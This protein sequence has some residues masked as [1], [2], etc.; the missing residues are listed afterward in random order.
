MGT[1]IWLQPDT[2]PSQPPLNNPQIGAFESSTTLLS[3][4]SVM[5]PPT[6]T[7]SSKNLRAHVDFTSPLTSPLTSPVRAPQHP[8]SPFSSPP[9]VLPLIQDIFGSID[10]R[11]EEEEEEEDIFVSTEGGRGEHGDVLGA[12]LNKSQHSHTRIKQKLKIVFDAL[13]DVRWSISQFLEACVRETDPGGRAIMC[14]I[15]GTLAQR[16]AKVAQAISN[17][18][19]RAL[20]VPTVTTIREELRALIQTPY[21]GQFDHISVLE[22]LNFNNA[23]QTV[24]AV[25]PVWHKLLLTLMSNQR[26][27]R[28]KNYPKPNIERMSRQIF[29]ITSIICSSQ[30]SKNSNFFPSLVDIYL[31][32]SGVKRR[33]IET[34]SG[35][36]ICHSYKTASSALTKIAESARVCTNPFFPW[37]A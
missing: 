8:S 16:Q 10:D 12:T 32:G 26:V 6:P 30:A 33:V 9:N 11:E 25:A 34:L 18:F 19:I 31:V 21:Y 37:I 15:G 35:F 24:E 20:D 28:K 7:H 23:F 3:I 14:D 22:R 36:G 1:V 17:P 4:A 13:R 2:S 5:D 27:N 29:T